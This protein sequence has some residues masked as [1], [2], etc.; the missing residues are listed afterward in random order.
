MVECVAC[1]GVAGWDL[2]LCGGLVADCGRQVAGWVSLVADLESGLMG[3]DW[4][5]GEGGGWGVWRALGWG[6]GPAV[7]PA[8][9]APSEPVPIETLNDT[10]GSHGTAV[11]DPS[12]HALP[13][14]P[15]ARGS[16]LRV[17]F[18]NTCEA[19]AA[20]R[21]L[22]LGKAK[23]Y[24]QAVLEKKRAIPFLH[25][26]GGV[27]RT[28]QAKNEGNKIGQARWPAKSATFL[29]GLLKNA[30]A[31][32]ETKGL[33][34]DALYVSH[35]QVN[36][37]QRGRRRTYRAHGRINPYMSSPSHIELILT[38]RTA[39]V[40][41][42]PDTGAVRKLSKREAARKLRSGTRSRASA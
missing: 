36:Q 20:I 40:R 35:I 7:V 32:A 5:G 39:V 16:D 25:F 1:G 28:S 29:L 13:L 42:E 21:G 27:G 12:S 22:N 17:H 2:V 4:G 33:D 3:V 41:A 31:N 37:A 11:P 14:P 34:V 6:G 10:G 30:E 24:L 15:Q 19:A 26:N 18:K 38:E 23:A 9:S 8:P